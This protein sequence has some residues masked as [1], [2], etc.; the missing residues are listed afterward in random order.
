MSALWLHLLISLMCL[1]KITPTIVWLRWELNPLSRITCPLLYQLATKHYE[2]SGIW[3]HSV[4]WLPVD[5]SKPP[6][7]QPIAAYPQILEFR[8]LTYADR[9]V[10]H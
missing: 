5:G 8:L 10:Q 1:T 7:S 3:T 4:D 9:L 6:L 2:D